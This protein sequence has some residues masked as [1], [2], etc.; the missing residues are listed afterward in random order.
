[1]YKNNKIT[2]TVVCRENWQVNIYKPFKLTVTYCPFCLRSPSGPAPR[3]WASIPLTTKRDSI[4]IS[5]RQF[6][7]VYP[8]SGNNSFVHVCWFIGFRYTWLSLMVMQMLVHFPSKYRT[9]SF[10]YFSALQEHLA[11]KKLP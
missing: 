7:A 2:S 8:S 9:V 4:A 5:S 3:F 6:N 11:H 10:W 1:M